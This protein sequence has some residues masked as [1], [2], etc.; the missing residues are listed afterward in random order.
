MA[1][2]ENKPAVEEQQPEQ[3]QKEEQKEKKV[4]G[5]SYLK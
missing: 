5:K 3:E 1:D 2:T 4:I